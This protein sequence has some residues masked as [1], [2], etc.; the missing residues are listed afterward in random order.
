[1]KKPLILIPGYSGRDSNNFGVGNHYLEFFSKF[2][3]V[4]I[5]MPHEDFVEGDLLVLPGGMDLNPFNYN[6]TPRF[7]AGNT[8]VHKQYFYDVRLQNYVGKIPIFGI[9]LGMQQLNVFLGGQLEQN[10]IFHD[11]SSARWN[12]AHD[13]YPMKCFNKDMI[14]NPKI[15]K[16]NKSDYG[17]FAVNSHHHQA[18]LLSTLSEKLQP[19]LLAEYDDGYFPGN[20]LDDHIVEAFI[21]QE[22]Q[23]IGVQW[24]PEELYDLFSVQAV[25]DLISN[26]TNGSL[27]Y[28]SRRAINEGSASVEIRDNADRE[29]NVSSSYKTYN[30]ELSISDLKT[31]VV[32]SAD[33]LESI[34]K[35]KSKQEVDEYIGKTRQERP[36]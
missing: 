28:K 10:L 30:P 25:R 23:I 22:L 1:M 29:I 6:Q 15:N 13:V 2:G 7:T 21:S 11:Q 34:I 19:L 20:R 5:L 18:V 36:K 12:T 8:D 31:A 26:R 3:N 16:N 27:Q 17:V 24:H 4:R 14:L 32:A 33:E 35:S 9:C